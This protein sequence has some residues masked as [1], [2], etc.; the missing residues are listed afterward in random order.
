MIPD[1]GKVNKVPDSPA[2]AGEFLQRTGSGGDNSAEELI[3]FG[4]AITLG[5]DRA[6]YTGGLFNGAAT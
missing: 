5:I 6:D 3:Q 1:R 2:C 4:F